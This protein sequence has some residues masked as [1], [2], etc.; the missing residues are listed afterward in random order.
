M[1]LDKVSNHFA[2][3]ELECP[4][5]CLYNFD[6]ATLEQLEAFRLAAG[7]MF[8]VT[9]ACRCK[10]NNAK[11]QG[12]SGSYHIATALQAARA[13]DFRVSGLS[14]YV[15]MEALEEWDTQNKFTGRGIYPHDNF[16]HIDTGHEK[17]TRWIRNP[18]GVYNYVE[19][20]N[21]SGGNEQ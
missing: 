5:C 13:I 2:R 12:A 11:A 6:Q 4:C 20:F 8:L 19:K 10:K 1:R 14:A 15:L 18:E 9:S 7:Q 17:V 16:I 3:I 21:F